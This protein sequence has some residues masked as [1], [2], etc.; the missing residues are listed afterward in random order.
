MSRWSQ[1]VTLSLARFAGRS[2]LRNI[3]CNLSNAK[4][5][6]LGS[7]QVTRTSLARVNENQ[8]YTLYEAL[9]YQLLSRC[10]GVTPRQSYRCENKFY[11]LDAST[12]DP[13]LSAFPGAKSPQCFMTP[14]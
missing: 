11:S 14:M 1:F 10:Q 12:I 9:F 13:C 4:L 5:Y 7:A 3:V 2:S 8:P 6:H